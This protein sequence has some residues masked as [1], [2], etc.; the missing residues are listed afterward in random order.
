[1]GFYLIKEP[2]VVSIFKLTKVSS[3]ILGLTLSTAG[4]FMASSV[5]ADYAPADTTH[6][7]NAPSVSSWKGSG[8]GLGLLMN[9]GDTQNNNLN[10]NLNINYKPS[11]SWTFISKDTFQRASSKQSGLT[12]WQLALYAQENYNFSTK[13]YIYAYANYMNDKFDGYD[14]RLQESLGYGRNISVPK[15]MSLSVQF[16]PGF[17]QS[18]TQDTGKKENIPTA[19]LGIS[20]VWNFTKKSSFTENLT[21][22][23]SKETVLTTSTTV[24][25]TNI[26]GNFDMQ[27]SYLL[28]Q[29][30][31]PVEGKHH[32]NTATTVSVIYT[33]A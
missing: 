4:C 26:R 24:L 22:V 19:N 17:E 13:N 28:T 33:F 32:I 7:I 14:Y 18:K 31:R 5:F 16:G 1:M 6:A 30:T 2:I 29:S 15:D 9:T 12:A 20:Y 27:L 3:C 23:A 21:S 11:A 25:T 10:S 8:A